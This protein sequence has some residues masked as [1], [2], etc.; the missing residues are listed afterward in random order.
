[1][2]EFS[3]N[4]KTWLVAHRG[5]QDSS[6]ENT[7]SAFEQASEFGA[8]F[9]ECDIQFTRDLVPVVIHD[10][11]LKR[12]CDLALHV[13]LLDLID[14]KELCYPYFKLLRLSKLIAWLERT[15]QLSLFIEVKPDIR[16]RLND[17]EIADVLTKCLPETL[18]SRIILISEAGNILDVCHARLDCRIG[19][20]AEGNDRPDSRLDYV[21]MPYTEVAS[22][23]TWHE[24]GI[25]VGLYTLNDAKLAHEMRSLGADLIE[26]NHYSRMLIDL[27][28]AREQ[29]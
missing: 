2:K 22:I 28:E 8:Q 20:V 25:K 15:P 21:F 23:K 18:L 17:N 26:T 29:N 5:D 24:R 16:T 13:S 12:L 27:E 1:M 14:L 6:V 19:W 4:P 7:L 11:F 3:G 10:D 9:A